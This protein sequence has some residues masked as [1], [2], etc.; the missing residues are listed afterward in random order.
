MAKSSIDVYYCEQ[1]FRAKN[2]P[3]EIL[4]ATKARRRHEQGKLYTAL[5]GDLMRPYCFLE[6][7]AYRSVCVE[8]LDE[9]LRSIRAH[10]F[11]EQ[12]P[13]ELFLSRVTIRRY[14]GESRYVNSGDVYYFKVDGRLFIERYIGT[15]PRG[16]KLVNTEETTTDVSRNWEPFP[17]FGQ[18]DGLATLD[19][20]IPALK[21]LER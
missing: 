18:Y 2:R 19:R 13:D 15:P 17:E 12:R 3:D 7:S 14:E 8:F 16:S 6:F 20:G 9:S 4:T 1:W 21:R 5:M 10:S 11:Q